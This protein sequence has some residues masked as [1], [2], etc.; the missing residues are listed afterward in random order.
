[1]FSQAPKSQAFCHSCP[2]P[3]AEYCAGRGISVTGSQEALPRA[4]PIYCSCWGKAGGGQRELATNDRKHLSS[5][6]EKAKAKKSREA[7]RW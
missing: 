3:T 6:T 7:D 2:C 5:T 4:M 1:L